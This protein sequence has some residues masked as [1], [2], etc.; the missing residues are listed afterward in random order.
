MSKKTKLELALITALGA[1]LEAAKASPGREAHQIALPFVA[2]YL[3]RE[4]PDVSKLL[5]DI[6]QT[7][8]TQP[9]KDAP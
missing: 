4:W 5:D 7:R 1:V 9:T 6:V 2:G 8:W 3:E